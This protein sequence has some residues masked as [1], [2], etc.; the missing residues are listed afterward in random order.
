MRQIVLVGFLQAQN[1]TTIPAAWRHPEARLDFTSPDYYRHIGRTLERGRFDLGFF[2]DRLAMPDM[3]S[4]DHV[5]TVENGI[6]CV[7]MDPTAVLMTLGMATQRLGLGATYSTTYYQPFHVARLFATID[8]MTEGR[9]AWNV[10]TSVNDNEARNM[11][12]ESVIAHDE[13]YDRADEF[14]EVVHGHWDTWDDDALV[15]D[16]DSGLFAHGD[17]VHR[18]DHEGEQFRSRGPFT[19]PR[20]PQGHP[21]VIQAGQSGRGQRFAARWGELLFVANARLEEGKAAYA[22]VRAEAARIGRDPDQIRITNLVFPV[23]GRTL[24]EAEDKKA[25][26]DEL[27]KD[28]D[29]LSL[30]SEGLNF[31]F[32]TKGLDEPFTDDELEGLSGIQA[33]RDRVI[34][35]TGNPQPT[36]RDFMR[37][38]SRASLN[39]AIVGGPT[40]LADHFEAWFT[41]PA[42]DGFVIGGSY[43]PGTFED[44]VDVVVPELQRRGLFRTAYSGTT[45][46]DHLGLAVPAAGAWKPLTDEQGH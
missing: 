18:L 35:H 32:S 39:H 28:I 6:R 7:K 36:V 30:L 33:I 41:E 1:C 22:K 12:L 10:V 13:R 16:R 20:T 4:G 14:M 34:Q 21:V 15:L 25:A 38:T 24:S 43:M 2:D 23:A 27:P 26:Y 46:R 40:E 37:I 42:C 29:E 31:D 9:A 5:H 45:L 3:Y 19:V 8:H 44:F 17:R 11:G